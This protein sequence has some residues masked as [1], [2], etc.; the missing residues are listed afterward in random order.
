ME[1]KHRRDNAPVAVTTD[2]EDLLTKAVDQNFVPVI[3]D[4]GSFIGII[5]RRAIMRYCLDTYITPEEAAV[6]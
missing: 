4:K 3:D 2:I 1:I 5:T 6:M